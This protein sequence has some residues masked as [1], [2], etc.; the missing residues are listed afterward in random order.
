MNW[1]T[2]SC[3]KPSGALNTLAYLLELRGIDLLLFSMSN[4][5]TANHPGDC[6]VKGAT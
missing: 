4:P 6:S 5:E 1:T 2:V 3:T